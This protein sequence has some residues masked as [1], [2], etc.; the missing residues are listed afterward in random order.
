MQ[1]DAYRQNI[2][3][4]CCDSELKVFCVFVRVKIYKLSILV[5]QE[6][7]YNKLCIFAVLRASFIFV[8]IIRIDSAETMLFFV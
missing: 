3:I 6:I 1:I 2:V 7:K 5:P 8:F 4:V